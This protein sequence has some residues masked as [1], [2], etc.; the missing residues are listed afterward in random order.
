[1]KQQ[2]QVWYE[3]HPVSP[4]RKRELKEMGYRIVD[5][6]YAPKQPETLSATEHDDVTWYEPA[7]NEGPIHIYSPRYGSPS[8]IKRGRPRKVV[9]E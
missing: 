4:E 2:K 1:M 6:I 7:K 9:G 8:I 5:A 3:P